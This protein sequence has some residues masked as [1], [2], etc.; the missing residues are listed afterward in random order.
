MATVI[1]KVQIN[2]NFLGDVT[3]E[4]KF[5]GLTEPVTADELVDFFIRFAGACGYAESS[6]ASTLI[7]KGNEFL[8]TD[9][10]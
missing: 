8:P 9:M 4:V 10:Q 7:S 3:T 1:M 6:I 5:K 2:N